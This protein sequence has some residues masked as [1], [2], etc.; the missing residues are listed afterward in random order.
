MVAVPGELD[1]TIADGLREALLGV[2]NAGALG[3]V[4]DMTA[5][6]FCDSAGIT[7]ISRAA[8]RAAAHDATI[9]L[10]A[11]APAVLRVLDLVGMDRLINVY[12]D[13]AAAVASLPEHARSVS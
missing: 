6:T 7:A 12:P 8:R 3:L 1:L 10:A 4:V 9:R 13:T 5:T 2:L 11:T